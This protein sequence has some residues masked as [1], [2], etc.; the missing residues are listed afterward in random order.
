M[1]LNDKQEELLRVHLP[2]ELDLLEYAFAVAASKAQGPEQSLHRLLAIDGF[3]LHAR[4]LIEFYKGAVAK[5]EGRTAAAGRFTKG[6]VEYPSF[7][8]VDEVI[9][10]QV[11]HLNLDRGTN[12][13]LSLDGSTLTT[14]KTRL[15]QCLR[16]FQNGLTDDARA[17]WK[18]RSATVHIVVDE[19]MAS[20]C[21]VIYESYTSSYDVRSSIDRFYYTY[22]PELNGTLGTITVGSSSS[23]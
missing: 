11:A 13:K 5:T 15:D 6:A 9:N 3:Y 4:N 18:E 19:S 16:L 8:D 1:T 10:D 17:C 14:I 7:A 12:A 23:G 20:A 21:T 2:Y 22:N